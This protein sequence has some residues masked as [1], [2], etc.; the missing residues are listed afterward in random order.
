MS[1]AVVIKN[2]TNFEYKHDLINKKKYN[3]RIKEKKTME[4][5]RTLVVS[6][7]VESELCSAVSMTKSEVLMF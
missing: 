6:F 4:K 2:I 5:E 1:S 7:I 3:Q